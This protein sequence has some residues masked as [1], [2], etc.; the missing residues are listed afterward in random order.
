[1]SASSIVQFGN[2]SYTLRFTLASLRQFKHATGLSLWKARLP[3]DDGV[4]RLLDSEILT[5]IVWA[6]ML[7]EDPRLTF[8]KA[9]ERLQ[10]Y[11]E[12]QEGDL[13]ELYVAIASAFADSGLFGKK[14]DDDKEQV[15]NV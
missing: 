12:A 7:H 4:L 3:D 6:G 2:K 9:E 14:Q 15:P 8:E 11:V 1:M 10:G 13:S 5:H